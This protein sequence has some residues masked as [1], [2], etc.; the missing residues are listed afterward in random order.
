MAI[1]RCCTLL[2]P[3]TET[4]ALREIVREQK[5]KMADVRELSRQAEL[6]L[7]QHDLELVTSLLIKIRD[8]SI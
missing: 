8:A 1:N 2:H 4:Q 7:L 5:R 3:L 6:A